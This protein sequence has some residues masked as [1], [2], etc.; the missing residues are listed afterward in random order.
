[1]VRKADQ[2]TGVRGGTHGDFEI[3]AGITQSVMDV[4]RSSPNWNIL[5]SAQKEAIHMIIHKIHRIVSGDP[6]HPDHWDDIE[7]YA[8]LGAPL[9]GETTMAPRKAAKPQKAAKATKVAKAAKTAARKVSKAAKAPRKAAGGGRVL[10][11]DPHNTAR[12]L[13]AQQRREE[14]AKAAKKAGRKAS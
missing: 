10:L 14:A 2:L 12:R 4:L 11:D 5:R 6:D 9:K 7:G 13:R 1:M 8:A 3:G